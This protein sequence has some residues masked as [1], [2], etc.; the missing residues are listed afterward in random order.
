[1]QWCHLKGHVQLLHRQGAALVSHPSW[2]F[3]PPASDAGACQHA[4]QES[5]LS[6]KHRS[7]GEPTIHVP[8][9]ATPT[10]VARRAQR[11]LPAELQR[12]LEAWLKE[13]L[14]ILTLATEGGVEPAVQEGLET[15]ASELLVSAINL[16]STQGG[17]VASTMVALTEGREP[18][19][20]LRAYGR[21]VLALSGKLLPLP[22]STR[23][24]ME[25]VSCPRTGPPAAACHMC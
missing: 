8:N 19:E 20:R 5:S 18:P 23:A 6:A 24:A 17:L 14:H 1:M 7:T 21:G 15:Y 4:R 10:D 3:H 13:S 16:D 22:S 12:K 11:T 25:K 9:R 2:P